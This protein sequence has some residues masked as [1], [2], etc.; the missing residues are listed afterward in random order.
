MSTTVVPEHSSRYVIGDGTWAA[1][2]LART[3]RDAGGSFDSGCRDSAMTEE[4]TPSRILW[5]ILNSLTTA[6]VSVS[7]IQTRLGG[8]KLPMISSVNTNVNR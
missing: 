7:S 2:Y 5:E 3:H 1:V 4:S 8:G 6:T